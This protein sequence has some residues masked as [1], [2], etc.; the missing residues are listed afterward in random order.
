MAALYRDHRYRS[1]DGRL[2]LYARDY[3]GDGPPLLLMHGLTRNSA[4]FEPF[5]G[6]LAGRHRLIVPDQRGRGLSQYDDDP[7]NYRPDVYCQDMLALL[8]GLDI[9]TAGLVGTSMGGLMAIGLAATLPGRFPC[10]VLNDI[11]PQLETEGLDRI[12]GYVGATAPFAGWDNA[13]DRC[14][15]VNA[16]AFPDFAAPD[17]LA[18]ARRICRED[19]DGAVILAYDPMIAHSV[20]G[21]PPGTVPPNIWPLWD[22]LGPLPVLLVRGA[23]T[24][25]LSPATVAQMA[26]RHSG[27]FVTVEVPLRGH[28]PLLDEPA[29]L[30]ALEPFLGAHLR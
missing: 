15:A 24:D 2:D 4:D 21:D 28:A 1:A 26:S 17:W 23:L 13:A 5:A 16:D 3:A 10:V 7:A 12:R 20:L 11:G 9:G 14:A 19:A 29:V 6:H 18:F 8:D 30:A 25:L 22:M 27:P